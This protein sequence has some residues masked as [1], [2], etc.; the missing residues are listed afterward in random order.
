MGRDLFR[1]IIRTAL[2]LC[3]MVSCVETFYFMGELSKNSHDRYNPY[4]NN[5]NSYY[6]RSSTRETADSIEDVDDYEK[7]TT[8]V[9]TQQEYEY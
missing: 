6:G 4:Y 7:D 2:V 9:Y 1:G 8:R 5:S 3:L